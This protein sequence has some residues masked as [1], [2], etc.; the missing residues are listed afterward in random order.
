V[1]YPPLGAP[2]GLL[3]ASRSQ[4]SAHSNASVVLVRVSEAPSYLAQLTM[5]PLARKSAG[6]LLQAL[7]VG[8]PRT[9]G[10]ATLRRVVHTV[11]RLLG[12]DGQCREKSR[13]ERSWA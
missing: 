2:R 5:V 7:I 10:N 8:G 11:P 9:Q 1:P 13:P 6:H 12:R 3:G 4:P